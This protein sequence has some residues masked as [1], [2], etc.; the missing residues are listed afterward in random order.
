MKKY[1]LLKILGIMF[2]VSIVLTWLIP[3]GF[4]DNGTIQIGSI[5][6]LG[7]FDIFYIPLY[8]IIAYAEYAVVILMIG[9]LYGVL[10]KTGA[11]ELLIDKTIKKFKSKSSFLVFSILLFSV[12]S[13]LTGLTF[14]LL[15]LVP[16]FISV[17]T[18][19]GYS[20]LTALASTV[21]AILVGMIGT[22]LG[23][24]QTFYDGELYS[25]SLF[26]IMTS[27]LYDKIG[28]RV[29]IFVI[30]VFLFS[31]T[32]LYNAKNELKNNKKEKKEKTTK[33][34][35]KVKTTKVVET[36]KS[37]VPILVMLVILTMVSIFTMYNWS[38]MLEFSKFE[39]IYTT[40]SDITVGENISILNILGNTLSSIGTFGNL[41]LI[42]LILLFIL[43]ISIIYSV[44]F[45]ET[46]EGM[47][48]GMKASL[49]TALY[50]TLANIIMM[51][52]TNFSIGYII[53][54]ITKFVAELFDKFNV[55]TTTLFGAVGGLLYNNLGAF[56][57]DSGIVTQLVAATPLQ[58]S[59]F[60][61]SLQTTFNIL[62]MI[63]PTSI[64]LIAGLSYLDIKYTDW[65]KYIWKFI[66]QIFI[67]TVM[68]AQITY[69][70][71]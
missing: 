7:L 40:L 47:K 58:Y 39:N 53:I 1:N 51:V 38:S 67:I 28:V 15:I 24:I 19:M 23:M 64:I 41:Q 16:Y 70:L 27:S 3:V 33:S 52:I 36:K 22:T 42:A 35:T 61:I 12:L 62:M 49:K 30:A 45:D 8:T 26:K 71:F 54:T 9:A 11:Y 65:L 25:F 17:I 14:P 13:S 2:L 56:I 46:I 6:P 29:I 60:S 43:F 21:G 57:Y 34:A 50:V 66:I 63:L 31:I 68:I 18:K 5:L 48:E 69:M 59:V 37:H 55:I 44:S 20:K 32:V 4:D 10:Y